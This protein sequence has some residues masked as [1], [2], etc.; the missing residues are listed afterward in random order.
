M[1]KRLETIAALTKSPV[2]KYNTPETLLSL[3]N[4]NNH[5]TYLKKQESENL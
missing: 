2:L 1:A 4:Y 5:E 3:L